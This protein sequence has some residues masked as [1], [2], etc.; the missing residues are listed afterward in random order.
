MTTAAKAFTATTSCGCPVRFDW[1]TPE[2]DFM[3]R[4]YGACRHQ[5]W[6]L[7]MTLQPRP[8]RRFLTDNVE[9]AA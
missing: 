6:Q 1:E 2:H 7:T 9:V 3:A 8:T 5:E 4:L